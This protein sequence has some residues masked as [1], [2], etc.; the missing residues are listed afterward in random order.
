VHA[1]AIEHAEGRPYLATDDGPIGLIPASQLLGYGKSEL[2]DAVSII[3]FQH[4]GK[5]YGL[6]VD[7]C[8]IEQ[9]IVEKPLDP[10]LGKVKDIHAGAFLADGS[11]LLVF[12]VDDLI[13]S[14]DKLIS[15]D[16]VVRLESRTGHASCQHILVVDDSITVR[17]AERR[18][19]ISRGYR[20][21]ACIDGMD[22]WNALRADSFDLVVTDI[23]MP[24]MNG[25]ELVRHIKHASDYKQIP[26]IIV[27]YKESEEDRMRGMEAGADYYLTKSSFHDESMLNAV[28]ELIGDASVKK[29][30]A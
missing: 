5:R 29:T 19:L 3:V 4:R 9:E 27:S 14:M 12:D 10:R 23:D 16:H 7:A 21:T 24:R 2:T 11:T 6:I 13:C 1:D 28:Y 15:Q 22:G 20:V 8:I 17:E 25:L 30:G 26:V 18:L